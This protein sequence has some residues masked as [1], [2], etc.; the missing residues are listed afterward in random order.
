MERLLATPAPETA[1]ELPVAAFHCRLDGQ[2]DHLVPES[3][4]HN[5]A[6]EHLA[7]RQ[8][9]LNP[10][11]R[12]THNGELPPEI[13]GAEYLL[14]GF[15][16]QN[17]IAW[18]SDPGGRGLQPF[19]LEAELAGVLNGMLPG[20]P[21]TRDL[22]EPALVLTMAGIL[23]EA[24]YASRRRSE[25]RV[26]LIRCAE[27]FQQRGFAPLAGLIHPLHVAALRRYYRYLLRTGKLHLGDQQTSKRYVA[28]NETVARFFHHQLTP[29]MSAVAGVRV[30]PSYVYVGAYQGG[31]ALKKH[32]DREQCE[33][34]ISFC[35]DYSPE[36]ARETP[37]PLHLQNDAG[38]ITVFQAIG[39]ALFYRGRTLAHFRRDL[40]QSNT[41][42]SIFFHYVAEEFTGSLD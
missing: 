4:L 5:Q 12:I 3:F 15:A 22:D 31:A 36:P 29:A 21:W 39:D 11:I 16:L 9:F 17:A 27:Q 32:T 8:L 30:K 33:F 19:W 13:S 41:S 38:T 34:S 24:G 28:H 23:V 1:L 2:P 6:W 25:W 18:I 35:L 7:G 26:T 37:W 40:P 20:D 14:Q 42:T 10:D